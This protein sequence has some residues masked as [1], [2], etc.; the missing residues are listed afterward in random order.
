MAAMRNPAAGAS[1][2][3]TILVVEDDV[4]IRLDLAEELRARGVD[5]IE[6]ADA[7][8]ATEILE[9][10]WRIDLVVSDVQMPGAMDGFGLAAWI[11][12]RWPGLKVMLTSAHFQAARRSGLEGDATFIEKP[13]RTDLLVDRIVRDLKAADA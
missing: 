12:L 7:Q 6:A 4:L 8:Q 10:G 3:P 5:V 13:Y 1:V 11:W 2:G 9:S